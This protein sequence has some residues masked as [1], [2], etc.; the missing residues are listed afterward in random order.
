[1]TR[2]HPPETPWT[3]RTHLSPPLEVEPLLIDAI[4]HLFLHTYNPKSVSVRKG[5]K[6][7]TKAGTCRQRRILLDGRLI[8]VVIITVVVATALR[9]RIRLAPSAFRE[10]ALLRFL[11][12]LLGTGRWLASLLALFPFRRIV[13]RVFGGDVGR[14]RAQVGGSQQ[15]FVSGTSERQAS[16][17]PWRARALPRPTTFAS[18]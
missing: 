5:R 4:K 9:N 2:E 7:R 15:E 13:L 3:K 16:P 17:C 14:L 10:D 8:I 18:A 1:V 6:S 11:R 12:L